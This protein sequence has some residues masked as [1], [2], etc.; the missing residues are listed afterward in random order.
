MAAAEKGEDENTYREYLWDTYEP[1]K[2]WGKFAIIG[3]LSMFAMI[4]YHIG[5]KKANARLEVEG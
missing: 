2:M 5:I 1:Y 4:L 3:L